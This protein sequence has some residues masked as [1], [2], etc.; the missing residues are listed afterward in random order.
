MPANTI[1]ELY[2]ALGL[3]LGTVSR[4]WE[5]EAKDWVTSV[6]VSDIDNDGEFEVIACSRDGRVQLLDTKT[7]RCRW[8]RIVGEKAW[9][10]TST[11]VARDL[12][13]T[14]SREDARIIVG[15]RDGKVYIL[16]K[17]GMT[18]TRQGKLLP[19]ARMAKLSIVKRKKQPAGWIQVL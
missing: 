3:G 9:I 18:I 19:L 13:A 12:L 14:G 4:I 5:Y 7:G 10:G 6:T 1:Q 15:T 2:D 8:Q 16:N 11:V 17:D